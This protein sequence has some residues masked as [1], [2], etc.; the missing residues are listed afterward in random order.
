MANH[1]RFSQL[2]TPVLA[3]NA[4]CAA[5]QAERLNRFELAVR[6]DP[7]RFDDSPERR[8]HSGVG[9]SSQAVPP[10]GLPLRQACS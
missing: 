2:T 6:F 10:T 8:H 3:G 5:A 1:D 9:R 4:A 7:L